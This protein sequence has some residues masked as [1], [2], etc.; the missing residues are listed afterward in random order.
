[1]GIIKSACR[2][3]SKELDAFL[4]MDKRVHHTLVYGITHVR[5]NG[6]KLVKKTS[7]TLDW[8]SEEW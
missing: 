2:F 5:N 6:R 3:A 8:L 7:E 1:M 4:V